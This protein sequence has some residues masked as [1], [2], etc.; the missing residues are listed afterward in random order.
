MNETPNISV[1]Q[2]VASFFPAFDP[3]E[4]IRRMMASPKWPQSPY[5]GMSPDDIKAA[6]KAKAEYGTAVHQEISDC[7]DSGQQHDQPSVE[8]TNQ[9]LPFYDR[10]QKKAILTARETE[11][12]IKACGL[13][14]IIDAIFETKDGEVVFFDWKINE[15]LPAHNFYERAYKPISHLQHAKLVVAWLQLNAYKYMWE[16]LNPNN[17]YRL[18]VVQMHKDLPTYQVHEA[19]N[20]QK[21]IRSMLNFS[22]LN[23]PKETQPDALPF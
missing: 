21:E 12:R 7:I 9:F 13:S 19:P 14:G 23:E 22:K 20:F 2:F 17:V 8:F 6:W 1:T 18:F 16:Q 4:A 11:H 5:F 3:D 15:K 10:L